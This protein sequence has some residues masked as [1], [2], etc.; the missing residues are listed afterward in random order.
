MQFAHGNTRI[1]Y[2]AASFTNKFSFML[3]S[4]VPTWNKVLTN[5]VVRDLRQRRRQRPVSIFVALI[6]TLLVYRWL[7]IFSGVEF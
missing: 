4:K 3:K 6:P 5:R 1:T 2:V 7:A